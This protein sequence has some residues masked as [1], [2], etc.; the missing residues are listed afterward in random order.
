MN[1]ALQGKQLT[2][3]IAGDNIQAFKLKLVLCKTCI[4]MFDSFPV[5]QL[6]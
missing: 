6:F 4:H 1:L 5:L 3:F 2:V